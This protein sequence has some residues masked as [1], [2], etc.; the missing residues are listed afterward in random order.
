MQPIV[1]Q[2]M[3]LADRL[4]GWWYR[5]AAPPEVPDEAPLSERMR[6]RSGKLTSVI[7]LIQILFYL[8]T[9]IVTLQDA[10][11]AAP[12]VAISLGLIL[13]GVFLNRKGKTT[14]AGILV[15]VALEVGL[16]VS[17][18]VDPNGFSPFTLGIFDFFV[19]P[20]LVAA[21]LLTS[22]LVLPVTLSNCL[23]VV[24]MITFMPKTPEMIQL[25][26]R[27]AYNV[28]ADS[29][30]VQVVAAL[31]AFLW[32]N[33]TYKEM[34][35]ANSA[36]E[37]SKLTME[38]AS[39]QQAVQEEKQQLEESIQ[40]L[41]SVHMQVANG[42]FNARVPL[43]QQ[44]VLWSVAGSLN[45]L[46]SRLQRWRQD[47]VLLQRNE[48]ALEQL[49]YNIQAARRQGTA[50]PAYRTGTSLDVLITEISKGIAAPQFSH[51]QSINSEDSNQG[52]TMR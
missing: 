5:I 15:L 6:V 42:N 25:L 17:I 3:S 14:F 1:T 18:L 37:V 27:Q 11:F 20:E 9:L 36:E 26:H 34:S 50:L 13:I 46:L 23:I 38:I 51:D 19:V 32:V 33:S 52:N 4:F 39:Q 30:M 41:V 49:L 31:V 7:F 2:E 10:R 45:N 21:S 43:D 48:Q 8:A 22:W 40:Q 28:Y 44:N 29:I 12:A 16:V 24:V 35:R 47:A